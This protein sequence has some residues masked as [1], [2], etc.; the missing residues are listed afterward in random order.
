MAAET[1]GKVFKIGFSLCR[2]NYLKN[3]SGFQVTSK[4]NFKAIKKKKES[5]ESLVLCGLHFTNSAQILTKILRMFYSTTAFFLENEVSDM[6]VFYFVAVECSLI[7]LP[8]GHLIVS[9]VRCFQA[10]VG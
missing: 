4:Q 8:S 2:T 6:V 5:V 9:T 10:S 1:K 3:D 7:R